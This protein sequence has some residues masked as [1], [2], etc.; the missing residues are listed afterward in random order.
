[1]ENT[2]VYAEL[3]AFQNTKETSDPVAY[4]KISSKK[5]NWGTCVKKHNKKDYQNRSYYKADKHGVV[6]EAAFK[7]P[8]NWWQIFKKTTPPKDAYIIDTTKIEFTI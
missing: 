7:W 6:T 4:Y 8:D 2:A 5:E 1:M 3:M